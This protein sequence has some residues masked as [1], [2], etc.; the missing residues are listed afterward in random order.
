MA[1]IYNNGIKDYSSDRKLGDI[2]GDEED[3]SNDC[4]NFSIFVHSL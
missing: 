3:R 4:C 2:G 1:D